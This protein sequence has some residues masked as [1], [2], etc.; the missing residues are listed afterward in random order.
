MKN[1]KNKNIMIF[2]LAVVFSIFVG[3]SCI[4]A[5]EVNQS[6][7]SLKDTGFGPIPDDG[8]VFV[9][10]HAYTSGTGW[11]EV[12]PET[13]GVDVSEPCYVMD[14]PDES[15]CS[16]GTVDFGIHV[17]SDDYYVKLILVSP[18]GDIVDEIVRQ[19]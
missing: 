16:S 12:S 3:M 15:G 17:N 4:A 9:I 7:D 6:D 10:S 11:W 1:I 14:P 5:A 2:A 8:N 19:G 18:S 13:H